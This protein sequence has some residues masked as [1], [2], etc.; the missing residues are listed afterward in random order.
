MLQTSTSNF[1]VFT[2][3]GQQGN[4][5][6]QGQVDIQS[7]ASFKVIFEGISKFL[8]YGLI[9]RRKNNLFQFI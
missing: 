1:T 4:V 6:S 8:L 5:W 3:N 2:R 7:S 9:R